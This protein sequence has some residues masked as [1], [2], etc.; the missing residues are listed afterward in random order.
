VVVGYTVIN[1]LGELV[2]EILAEELGRSEYDQ[3]ILSYNICLIMI[4]YC[5][6]AAC[7][8]IS[9]DLLPTLNLSFYQKNIAW[10]IFD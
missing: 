5:A 8:K 4:I 1:I 3:D 7:Q 10:P 6:I 2:L 9:L